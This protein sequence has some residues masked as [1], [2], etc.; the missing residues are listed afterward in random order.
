[1]KIELGNYTINNNQI[2]INQDFPNVSSLWLTGCALETISHDYESTL[3]VPSALVKD[4]DIVN[5][6]CKLILEIED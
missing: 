5:K 2:C 1:M 3:F 4:K 6:K